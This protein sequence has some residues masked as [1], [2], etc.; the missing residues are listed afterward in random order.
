MKTTQSI[1]EK[2]TILFPGGFKPCT[3][4]HIYQIN[5]YLNNKDVNEVILIIG[6]SPR[7]GI[8]LNLSYDILSHLFRRNKR[9]R[10]FK[11]K[12]PISFAFNYIESNSQL[13]GT[14]ALGSSLKNGDFL[15]VKE[16][17]DYF[18][19]KYPERIP[20]NV[21]VVMPPIQVEALN[22]INRNDCFNNKPISASILRQDFLN[23]DKKNFNANYPNISRY[24]KDYIWN[25]L[26]KNVVDTQITKKQNT[27]ITHLDDLLVT[28][29]NDGLK[30]SI[31]ILETLL[32]LATK[33]ELSDGHKLSIKIDGSPSLTAFSSFGT[34]RNGIAMKS[35][36]SKE[37][38]IMFDDEDI[39]IYHNDRP[40]LVV[41]LK[42]LLK[43][44][45]KMKIPKGEI[46]QGDYLYSKETLKNENET[47]TFHPNVL[48]YHV[49]KDSKFYDKIEGSELGM[50]WHTKYKGCDLK[51]L[52]ASYDVDINSLNK[53]NGVFQID[54]YIKEFNKIGRLHE[55][56]IWLIKELIKGLKKW[57]CDIKINE[58]L[59]KEILI[60]KNN[61]ISKNEW[62]N[63]YEFVRKLSEF[64]SNRYEKEISKLKTEKSKQNWI[65]ELNDFKRTINEDWFIELIRTS[66]YI[67]GI[68]EIFIRCLNDIKFFE[69][70]VKI[71]GKYEKVNQEGFVISDKIGNVI[72]LV[73]RYEFS[74]NN[75]DDKIERGWS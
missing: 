67:R 18:N 21:R 52:K 47:L 74:K 75:F 36:F 51:D 66:D 50:V 42:T 43:F 31:E 41:K 71:D 69:A 13:S 54:P 15:R 68:K 12:S 16:F 11:A 3:G 64:L 46:W 58:K 61:L 53:V 49:G 38:K 56:E 9:V 73:S 65:D 59:K 7:D 60:F 72:K 14:F 5:Q 22:Y 24:M 55:N 44:V 25:T 45:K 57:K 20:S 33:K 17:Y 1:S 70:S 6:D 39:E 2:V 32:N 48:A 40:E 30:L 10:I 35:I 27:H 26:K 23:N 8:D 63:E 29:G 28:H 37:P 34:M 19:V 62:L 4:A